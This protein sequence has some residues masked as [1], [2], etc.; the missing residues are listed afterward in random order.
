ME[1]M[2]ESVAMEYKG[3]RG[4]MVANTVYEHALMFVR[5]PGKQALSCARVC[6][7]ACLCAWSVC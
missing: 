7:C 5:V 1:F 4:V 6:A 3:G 2:R